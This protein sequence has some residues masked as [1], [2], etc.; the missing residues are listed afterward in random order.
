M[1]E[2]HPR[3]AGAYALQ[4]TLTTTIAPTA[5][6][7]LNAVT[8]TTPGEALVGGIYGFAGHFDLATG[9]LTRETTLTNLDLHAL[10]SDGAGATYAV[11]GRFVGTFT[12]VALVRTLT[13]SSDAT[14]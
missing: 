2:R 8:M 3:T 5:I 1:A 13:S 4:P 12:G 7:G 11:G 14:P 6:G 10:W 9:T